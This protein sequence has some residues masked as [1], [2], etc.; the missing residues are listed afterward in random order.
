[1]KSI[2]EIQTKKVKI[3]NKDLKLT[4][5]VQFGFIIGCLMGAEIHVHNHETS[6]DIFLGLPFIAMTFVIT[7]YHKVETAGG[8]L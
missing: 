2:I 6:Y 1:M 7:K 4:L 8:E 3:F 5:D